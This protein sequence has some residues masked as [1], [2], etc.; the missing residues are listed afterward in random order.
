MAGIVLSTIR[1][2][3]RS[4][5]CTPADRRCTSAPG[6]TLEN[7]QTPMKLVYLLSE[8]LKADPEYVSL[9]Q[10]LTLDKSRPYVGLNGT[11]G[12]FGSQEWWDSINQGKMPLL[13]LSGVIKK[14]YVAGQDPSDFNNTID[15]LLDDGT[16]QSVGIYT[17]Q[18]EDLSSFEK[19]HRA[20]I[21]YALDEL[22]PK[23]M[24]NFGQK[25]NKIALEMAVSL[26]PVE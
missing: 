8:E 10:A 17:N 2:N 9:T 19:G 7:T 1:Q 24:L 20:S 16:I 18:N 15:L 12:L 11:Y 22:K 25:Y 3:A 26:K 23:A 5:A 21:V 13:S 6:K 14:A 4:R